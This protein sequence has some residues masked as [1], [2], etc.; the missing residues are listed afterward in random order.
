MSASLSETTNLVIEHTKHLTYDTNLL[1]ETCARVH[2][3]YPV[4]S[5]IVFEN[6]NMKCDEYVLSL[7]MDCNNLPKVCNDIICSYI[8]HC[9][10]AEFSGMHRDYQI[11]FNIH[12]VVYEFKLTYKNYWRL[13]TWNNRIHTYILKPENN[14]DYFAAFHHT[15][16]QQSIHK[17]NNHSLHNLFGRK[18]FDK[19]IFNMSI[20][21]QIM[22]PTLII[23]DHF[24]YL[25]LPKNELNENENAKCL[26]M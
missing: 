7:I 13:S 9:I 17:L 23:R 10:S 12:N 16:I 14:D 5:T 26:I 2:D 24:Q 6:Y 11:N 22:Y 18:V 19:H 20:F 3:G 8:T 1:A 15:L 25:N 21:T 4:Q